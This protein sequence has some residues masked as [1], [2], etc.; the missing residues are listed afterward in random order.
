MFSIQNHGDDIASTDYFD[1]PL[2]G[3]GLFFLSWRPGHLRILVPDAYY[4]ALPEMQTALMAV[5]T[6]GLLPIGEPG[7]E[8]MFDD[9]SA[10]PFAITL[11]LSQC[12]CPELPQDT[13]FVVSAW[14]RNGR[15]SSWPGRYRHGVHLPCLKP[16]TT[17]HASP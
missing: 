8:V 12:D 6:R 2:A 4:S 13:E 5:V 10:E 3:A 7:L 17:A 15:A 16:W 1:S 14:T 9:A 11:G